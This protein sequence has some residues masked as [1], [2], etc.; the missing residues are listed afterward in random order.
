M[1]FVKLLYICSLFHFY[2]TMGFIS[3][4][5]SVI[6][7]FYILGFFGRIALGLWIR[8]KQKEF[9]QNG[10]AQGGFRTY[11]W[12][13]GRAG[14]ASRQRSD[15]SAAEGEVTIKQTHQEEKKVNSKIGDY[16][17]Y[18]EVDNKN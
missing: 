15:D 11:Y 10:G 12:G 3:F 1:L 4:I 2:L 7:G 17:D 9:S 13:T 18:E 5:L 16:V 14:S 8:K 6:I